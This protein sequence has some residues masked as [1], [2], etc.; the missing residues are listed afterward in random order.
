MLG[1]YEQKSKSAIAKTYREA[2]AKSDRTLEL[3]QQG[4]F[5]DP[6]ITDDLFDDYG[7]KVSRHIKK[8]SEEK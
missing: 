3:I 7:S 4:H 6:L 1:E 5:K 2:K 8:R